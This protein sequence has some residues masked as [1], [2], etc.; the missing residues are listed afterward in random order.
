METLRFAIR[1]IQHLEKLLADARHDE[2]CD[3]DFTVRSSSVS[4]SCQSPA[5]TTT[6][7]QQQRGNARNGK[8]RKYARRASSDETSDDNEDDRNN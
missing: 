1:Y 3:C 8:G 4:D 7:L 6:E 2:Q 5:V